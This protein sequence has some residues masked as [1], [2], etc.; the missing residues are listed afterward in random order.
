MQGVGL[1]ASI[2]S[3]LT[4]ALCL[5]K[6]TTVRTKQYFY[7]LF[8][9]FTGVENWSWTLPHFTWF[10]RSLLCCQLYVCVYVFVFVGVELRPL[11]NTPKG[12]QRSCYYWQRNFR[13]SFLLFWESAVTL[14]AVPKS[15]I[16]RQNPGS[17]SHTCLQQPKPNEA[18]RALS[19]KAS[20]T[21]MNHR[22]IREQLNSHCVPLL[23][24]AGWGV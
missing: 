2:P 4:S 6:A 14:D 17:I 24:W 15:C 12:G 7:L 8:Y 18:C 3:T 1:F 21:S 23:Q 11:P 22:G 10:A 9:H 19:G 20:R 5:C 16:F 13:R